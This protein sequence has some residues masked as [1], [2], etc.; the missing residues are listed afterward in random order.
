SRIDSI[1]CLEKHPNLSP[2]GSAV[3]QLCH[4]LN[5]EKRYVVYINNMFSTISLFCEL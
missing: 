3:L 5:P 2:T 4:T 1:A